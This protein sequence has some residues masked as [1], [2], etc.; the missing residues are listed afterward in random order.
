MREG[1]LDFDFGGSWT[2]LKYDE[3]GGFY[4]TK[5]AKHVSPTKA[6]DFLCIPQGN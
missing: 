3:N 1:H 5:M 4:K 2:V 6:V